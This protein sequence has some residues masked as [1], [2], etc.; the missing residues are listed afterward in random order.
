[1]FTSDATIL[2]A[3]HDQHRLSATKR[4][5]TTAGFRTITADSGDEV[6]KEAMDHKPE[7]IVIDHALPGINPA[8]VCRKLK[9]SASDPDSFICIISDS[10]I[11]SQDLSDGPG[12]DP[13]ETIVRPFEDRALLAHVRSMLERRAAGTHLKG[14]RRRPGQIQEETAGALT[15]RRILPNKNVIDINQRPDFTDALLNTATESIFIIDTSGIFVLMND[16][17]ARRLGRDKSRLIGRCAYDLI[18][19]DVALSRKRIIDKAVR[20]RTPDRFTDKRNGLELHHHIYP[21]LNKDSSVTHVAVFTKDITDQRNAE[22]RLKESEEK[23]K[24]LVE[25]INPLTLLYSRLPDDVVTYVSPSIRHVMGVEPEKVIGKKWQDA[26]EW[27]P[28]SFKRAAAKAKKVSMGLEKG[29]IETA[30]YHQDRSLRTLHVTAHAVKDPS[31]RIKRIDGIATDITDRKLQEKRQ[32]TLN[33]QLEKQVKKRTAELDN[34]NTA[35]QVLLN[36]R[37]EDK[38]ELEQRILSNLDTLVSPF[39]QQLKNNLASPANKKLI[40]ILE[41]SLNDIIAPFS[42][43][44]ADPLTNLTPTEIQIASMIKQGL[45]NKEIAAMMQI[46]LRTVTSHRNN[47]RKKLNLINTKKNLKAYLQHLA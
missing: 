11:P 38:A 23:Y 25:D 34:I 27:E 35:L 10:E 21:V 28:E 29:D 42:K 24:Q 39:L 41:S 31:G 20:T 43:K 6:V 5:L 30:F 45:A 14:Y 15:E 1:M 26:V 36:K 8:E 37:E 17:A 7:L 2:V 13:D 18:P 3:D 4:L 33:R 40:N 16:V 12:T 44:L 22:K 9:S 32:K 19:K 47:I 46:S